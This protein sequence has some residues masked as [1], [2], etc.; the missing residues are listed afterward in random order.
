MIDILSMNGVK[1]LLLKATPAERGLFLLLG[2]ATNQIN[3]L[4]KLVTIATNETP[5]NPI[6]QRVSGAQTQ[7]IVRLMIG[8]LWEAMRLVQ[9]RLLGSAIGKEF[10][11]TLD[12]QALAALERLKKWIGGSNMIAS[13]RN[14]YCF[15]Y[16]KPDDMEAAFQTALASDEMEEQDWGIYFARTLLNTSYF[17]SDYVFAHGIMK[18]VEGVNINEAHQ[19]LLG[20][21]APIANDFSEV[22]HGFVAALFLKYSGPDD[23]VMTVVA[24]I[25][26]APNIEELRLPFYVEVSPSLFRD[27]DEGGAPSVTGRQLD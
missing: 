8:V 17:V 12:P 21:L 25:D 11:Q 2:Y 10:I 26:N 24:K 15:H 18:A 6:E 13:V 14:D 9:S 4:L 5:K 7:I 23:L 1:E 20:S 3:V 22:A 19:K 27:Y 16:P